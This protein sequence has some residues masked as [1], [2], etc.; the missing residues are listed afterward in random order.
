MMKGLFVL[1]ASL[2]FFV[3]RTQTC[4]GN[5]LWSDEFDSTALDLNKWTYQSGDGCPSLCQWGNSELEYYTTSTNN[6]YISAGVLNMKAI[7]Q[8]VNSSSFTSSKIITKG[9]YSR[10]YGRFEARM[11]LP[12]GA[13][14][15]PAFWM[16]NVNN[17]WPTTGEIDIMEYRGD[18]TTITQGTLH[19]GS[20]SPN[21]Q[22]D[23]NSYTNSKSLDQDF[24]IYAVEWTANDIKWYFDSVLYKTETKNPNSLNPASNNVAWPWNSNFYIILNLAVGGWFTGVTTAGN[25][26]L[27]KPNFEIDYV[28]VYDMDNSSIAEIAYNGSS[29][30][31]PGKIEME[32]YDI[33]CGGA[34]YDS[35]GLN[36]GGQY[37]L[38]GVDIETCTD[39]GGGY[40]VGYSD[41][42][43]WMDYTV[44]VA[45]TKNYDLD[46]RLASGGTGTSALHVEVDGLNVTGSVSVS[47]S[48]G[49]QTWQTYTVKNIP[50]TQGK[51][52]VR[53]VFDGTNINSNYMQWK[54]PASGIAA[55]EAPIQVE[56]F[57]H[58]IL[59]HETNSA[60][61]F[62]YDVA[63][64]A[65][66]VPVVAGENSLQV[67]KED[68]PAGIYLYRI[69]HQVGK[70]LV[71]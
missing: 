20:T 40:D 15:W 29:D 16:L 61:L 37:R 36:K 19:Y 5:L 51:H 43:E 21:N 65:V 38:D 34:Y 39:V 59:F 54:D 8:T 17:T 60:A 42:G 32:N 31:I 49:W 48:G 35:D 45:Q 22:H 50:L 14:L 68:L 47:T 1:F 7:K 69:N 46:L 25:V 13:G 9:L 66:K 28:R 64:V 52:V 12:T 33:K 23:G 24:H 55:Y 58:K 18:Q 71:Y 26:V 27:T 3:A 44:T 2:L 62:I 57:A 10:T 67:N 6:T 56:D 41:I 53:M 70:F 30:A 11:R 4:N 63:G